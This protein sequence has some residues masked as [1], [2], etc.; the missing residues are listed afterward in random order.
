MSGENE[1]ALDSPSSLF[2]TISALRPT[3]ALS[4]RVRELRF[5]AVPG[6]R[7]R[8][9]DRIGSSL[10]IPRRERE[11]PKSAH[12]RRCHAFR[13]RSLHNL[14]C[15]PFVSPL[16]DLHA[17]RPRRWRSRNHLP[18]QRREGVGGLASLPGAQCVNQHRS[19]TRP[20]Q[21]QVTEIVG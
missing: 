2:P 8:V 4:M 17:P 13:R 21:Q 12:P 3:P 15:R 7:S 18:Q 14:I 9:S 10:P 11:R 16:D 5:G 20:K 1:A 6:A 19:G